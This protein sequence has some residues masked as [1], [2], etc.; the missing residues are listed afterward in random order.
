MVGD[1]LVG[2]SPVTRSLL[3]ADPTRLV[4]ILVCFSGL[5][6]FPLCVEVFLPVMGLCFWAGARL[7]L[8]VESQL[9][10]YS[11]PGS[12]LPDFQV[13]FHQKK[14]I[15]IKKITEINK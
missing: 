2:L 9:W 8:L 1:E 5:V 14:K 11:C 10:L 13:P 3:Q 6:V 7:A 4:L 12:G 15:K